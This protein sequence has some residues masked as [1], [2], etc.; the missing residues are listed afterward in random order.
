[1]PFKHLLPAGLARRFALAAAG[2]A[3]GAVLVISLASWRLIDRQ[4]DQA[5]HELAAR[6]RQFHAEA[7]GGNLT[8]LATRMTEMAASTILATGLVDSAGRETYLAPFLAG[9][10]QINGIPVQVLFTDFEGKTIASNSVTRFSDPQLDWF[11]QQL[12]LGRPGSAIFPDGTGFELVA[13]EPLIYSRTRSSEGALLYKISLDALLVSDS[14]QLDWSGAAGRVQ[15]AGTP[16]ATPAVFEPLGFTIRGSPSAAVQQRLSPQY[17]PVLLAALVLFTAVVLA[18]AR[19]ASLLTR[20]LRRLEAFSSNVSGSALSDERAPLGGAAEV[21]SL[22]ASI[23]RM[24]DRLYQ[25]HAALA[26]EGE[27]H[28][29]LAAALKAADTRKDEFLA[30]LAHEL[31]NPLAPISTG[32]QLLKMS[33]ASS[34]E[35]ARTS[36]VISRQAEHMVKLVDDLLDVSR[37]TRGLVSLDR[38]PLDFR[39]VVAAAVDQVRPLVETSGHELSLALPEAP[40][41]VTGD[42]V[43]LVQVVSN[44]LSNAAKYTPAGGRIALRLGMAPDD[45]Q[46][47]LQV[48]DNGQGIAPEL[49]PDIFALF[50]QGSRSSDRSQGGLGLG[51][52]LVKHLVELHEG[53]IDTSSEGPGKGATFTL[54]LPC[55]ELQALPHPAEAAPAAHVGGR[56]RLMVVDDNMDAAQTLAT[57]LELDGHQVAVAY[58]GAGALREAEKNRHDVFILD[59]GLPGMDGIELAQRLRSMPQASNAKLVALTG[60]GQSTDR[61]RTRA[62]G[63]DH[64]FV[65]PVDPAKLHAVLAQVSH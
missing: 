6:E 43:R 49:M 33:P 22:A 64:H 27:K 23:N 62:A 17:F 37:V 53:S 1:M 42:H 9:V 41:P 47:T 30:M 38:R 39:Q 10:R 8:A 46:M 61:A 16:V 7:V 24:L 15:G 13:M 48:E 19:L 63:F 56:L 31:R 28:A 35:V 18:G 40:V 52:S 26:R 57:L 36:D 51:L 32:A 44:L 34:P 12:E 65:K 3:A 55:C 11:R 2:L 5:L 29:Q 14:M 4:H 59:I 20:D 50:T 21:A 54:R 45:R 60:Y 25:Q 58:D